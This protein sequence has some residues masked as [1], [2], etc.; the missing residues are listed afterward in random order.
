MKILT[1]QTLLLG[2]YRGREGINSNVEFSNLP[3]IIY[4]EVKN[5]N[6]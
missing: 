6:I 1:N 3:F 5:E 2:T 4:K